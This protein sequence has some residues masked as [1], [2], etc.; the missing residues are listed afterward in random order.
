MDINNIL[1]E[2][3]NL[4]DFQVVNTR[5]LLDEGNTIPFISRYRKEK[6]GEMRDTLLRQ[7]HEK[8]VYLRNLESRKEDVIRL[9]DEQGKLT[10]EISKAVEKA[11]TLQEREYV[12]EPSKTKKRTPSP[13]AKEKGL[14][15]KFLRL[16]RRRILFRKLRMF[17][18]H[19]RRKR[20][21][22]HLL[23]RKKA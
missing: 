15:R 1:K 16:L 19:L 10:K 9:I 14:E 20:E 17:T 13:R 8:L 3:F 18:H 5:E 4:K 23:L 6:T 2:E 7:F 12:T 21:L 22:E 11:N